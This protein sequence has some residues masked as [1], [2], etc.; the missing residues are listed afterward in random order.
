ML[1]VELVVLKEWFEENWLKGSITQSSSH[2]VAPVCWP[3]EPH[4]ANDSL[5][6]IETPTAKL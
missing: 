5:S 1:K 4:G 6:T 3:M 2:F